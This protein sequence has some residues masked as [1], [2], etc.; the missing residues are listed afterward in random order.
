VV[1]TKLVFEPRVCHAVTNKKA[2]ILAIRFNPIGQRC[3]AAYRLPSLTGVKAHQSLLNSA[4]HQ[5][6]IA[7]KE[8]AATQTAGMA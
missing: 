7:A 6:S 3:G 5:P 1:T 8:R 4:G 2:N